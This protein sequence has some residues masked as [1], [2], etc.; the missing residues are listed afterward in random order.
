MTHLGFTRC[1]VDQ[2]IIFKRDRGKLTI[3]MVHVDDCTIIATAQFL[4]DGLKTN[5]A[6]HIEITNLGKLHWI[7]GI[8][9]RCT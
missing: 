8:E 3:V 4:I 5:M 6:K 2:A 7:L 9:I 1:N